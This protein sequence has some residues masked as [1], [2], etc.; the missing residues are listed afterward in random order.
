MINGWRLGAF[1]IMDDL[2]DDG[3]EGALCTDC[4]AFLLDPDDVVT[5]CF[6][7]VCCT[8]CG[9]S[10]L[11]VYMRFYPKTGPGI[12]TGAIRKPHGVNPILFSGVFI[13]S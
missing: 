10:D 13:A 4:G 3:A 9:S 5:D 11:A 6:G 8:F 2:F 12:A 1:L 7:S